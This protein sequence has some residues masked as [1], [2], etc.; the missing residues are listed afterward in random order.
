MSDKEV[1]DYIDR[2]RD[3]HVATIGKDGAP[4]LTTNWFAVV[5][6][7]VAFNSYESSQKMLNLKRDPRV[8]LLFAD[9]DTYGELRGV[10][11]KGRVRFADEGE[12]NLR[13]MKSIHDRNKA[14]TDQ[15]ITGKASPESTALKRICAIVD[16]EKIISWDHSKLPRLAG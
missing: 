5:D 10:S 16:V 4:H 7:K 1:W 3:M 2:Q 14:Y 13:I 8:T 9:G 15:K 11:I 12:E 6:G